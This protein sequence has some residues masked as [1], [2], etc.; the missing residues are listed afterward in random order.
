MS[1][2]RLNVQ[3][4]PLPVAA[5]AADASQPPVAAAAIVPSNLPV[6]AET[7]DKR[8]A[9]I[10]DSG[11]EFRA[12][13]ASSASTTLV[14]R[15]DAPRA[16]DAAKKRIRTFVG[17]RL[18]LPAIGGALSATGAVALGLTMWPLAIAAGT[19][20]VLTAAA[21]E[22]GFGR[23]RRFS[24]A[25]NTE[26]L[27]LEAKDARTTG[28]TEMRDAV[29]S[30]TVPDSAMAA[31]IASAELLSAQIASDDAVGKRM[32]GLADCAP[33]LEE[34]IAEAA[35]VPRELMEQARRLVAVDDALALS[36]DTRECDFAK[37]APAVEALHPEELVELAPAIL[38]VA[39]PKGEETEFYRIEWPRALYAQLNGV[40][41]TPLALPAGEPTE[42]QE[43]NTIKR[44]L[45]LAL[46]FR[47]RL[48][49]A[50]Y[51]D[52][53]YDYGSSAID[54]AA[55]TQAVWSV[56]ASWARPLERAMVAE[57]ATNLIANAHAR[58]RRCF[59]A[60]R[61]IEPLL[62]AAEVC[63]TA[64]KDRAKELLAAATALLAVG[65]ERV[66]LRDVNAALNAFE[67]LPAGDRAGI[68]PAV[69]DTLF[70]KQGEHFP[71]A[72]EVFSVLRKAQSAEA[73]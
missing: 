18:S 15:Y 67:A 19:G 38:T 4:Q 8:A 61:A 1:D 41:D 9:A 26:L 5:P 21:S 32:Q 64:D 7:L 71:G 72:A 47:E 20:V 49:D 17:A 14:L 31:T 24:I 3:L 59:H 30:Q 48:R 53:D 46:K 34:I 52:Y 29:R 33:I 62:R 6:V 55:V 40:V 35:R 56:N 60:E 66:A 23:L 57:I 45:E 13:A 63:T 37:L 50:A 36:P 70:A 28:F 42:P 12:L 44:A 27:R 73:R 69:I 16:L 10:R 43:P 58:E 25:K 68:A 22:L 54:G 65:H 39:F 11:G 51:N 2:V